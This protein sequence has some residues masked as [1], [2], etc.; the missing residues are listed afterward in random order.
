M[1]AALAALTPICGHVTNFGTQGYKLHCDNVLKSIREVFQVPNPEEI[2]DESHIDL[3]E[4]E[5]GTGRSG[6]MMIFSSDKRYIIK[7]MSA[8]DIG[9]FAPI[10]HQY[11]NHVKNHA[12]TTMMMRYYALM[13]DDAGKFWIIANNW[14][15]VKFPITWDLK[16]STAG[17]ISGDTSS[18]Q[19]DKDWTGQEKA[20]A[21]SPSQR[22]EVLH[23]V[24]SDALMLA[25][26]G[27]LDYSLIVGLLVYELESCKKDS[28][29]A[30][31]CHPEAG[32][33]EAGY[34]LGDFF[35]SIKEFYCAGG[36]VKQR[37]LGHTCMG[38]LTR[39]LKVYFTC[40]GMIDLLKPY[41][42]KTKAEYVV[43]AGWARETSAQ[44]PDTYANRFRKFMYDKVFSKDISEKTAP[45]ILTDQTCAAWGSKLPSSKKEGFPVIT[46]SCVVLGLLGGIALAAWYMRQ[47]PAQGEVGGET[48]HAY[49]PDMYN[50]YNP[51]G[52][53]GHDYSQHQQAQQP[54]GYLQPQPAYPG[55]TG[56]AGQAA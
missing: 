53:N 24:D 10:V 38:G 2:L 14:L 50:A 31:V 18:S 21:L 26:A 17:R 29:V 46:V 48:L 22:D 34:S 23:A 28:C 5:K 51:Q 44:P 32:C 27:L 25:N 15:P 1:S 47:K 54:G 12:S 20:I 49:Q 6:A 35:K 16:G 8:R 4:A 30:P 55:F 19:K 33:G 41:D 11:A 7:T 9:A 56:Y 52:G 42:A 43:T 45:L 39:G 36:K 3:S 13:E 37:A 40:F